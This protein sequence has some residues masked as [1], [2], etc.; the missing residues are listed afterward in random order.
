MKRGHFPTIMILVIYN[1]MRDNLDKLL[2][3]NFKLFSILWTY[4]KQRC[5]ARRGIFWKISC[6]TLSMRNFLRPGGRMVGWV[7]MPWYRYWS[8]LQS[9]RQV[10]GDTEYFLLPLYGFAK[11]WEALLCTAYAIHISIVFSTKTLENYREHL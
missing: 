8:K 2:L 7:F 10:E 5:C 1:T 3:F 11:I 4:E 9:P 6:K